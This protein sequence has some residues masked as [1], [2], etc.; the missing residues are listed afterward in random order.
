MSELIE[1]DLKRLMHH[2]MCK[3]DFDAANLVKE[4][5]QNLMEQRIKIKELEKENQKL[6]DV[7]T[8][9]NKK[10]E[11]RIT[12]LE[13]SLEFTRKMVKKAKAERGS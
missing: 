9:E 12:E 10:S 1:Q 3:Q 11:D 6:Y 7:M 13:E 8:A 5:F 2:M 4:G